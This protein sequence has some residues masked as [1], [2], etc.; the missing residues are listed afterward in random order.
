MITIEPPF[1]QLRGT[2]VFRDHERPAQ[3]YY[4]PTRTVL[5]KGAG[6]L[7]CT[8]YKY[9]RDLTDNPAMTPTK[10]KGAGLA[11]F[12]T[13]LSAPNLT[14]LQADLAS[15]TGLTD[16]TL[17]PVLFRSSVS[18][19][20][21]AHAKGDGLL[22]D[23]VQAHSAPLTMPHHAAFALALSAEGATLF[24]AAARGGQL[25]VGVVYEMRFLAL[26]PALHAKVWMDYERIYDHFSVSTGF[27]YYVSIKFDVDVAFL[28]EHDLVKIEITSFTDAV[29]AQRQRDAIMKLVAMRIQQDFFRSGMPKAPQ[30]GVAGPLG[31]MLNGLVANS[32]EGITSASA[33]FVL[34]ARVEVIRERKDFELR[35]DGRAAVEMTH[36]ASGFLSSMVDDRTDIAVKEIDLDDPFFAALDVSVTAAIDF[37][38]M[39]DLQQ[40]AVHLTYQQNRKSFTFRRGAPDSGRFQAALPRNGDDEYTWE[41]EFFFDTAQGTGDP[42]LA[43]GPFKSRDRALVVQ[44]LSL[45]HYQRL[46]VIRG[47]LDPALVPRLHVTLQLKDTSVMPAAVTARTTMRVTEGQPEA[48][49]RVHLPGPPRVLTAFARTDWEDSRGVV[50]DGQEERVTSDRVV[51]LGPY[52]E[53]LDVRVQPAIDWVRATSLYVEL[54]YRDSDE[55]TLRQVLFTK[56]S[57]QSATVQFPLRDRL[58]RTYEWRQTRLAQDGTS[59]VT[60]WLAS[61][62]TLLVVGG[63]VAAATEVRV[64]WVG[65]AGGALG[66]RVD[67]YADGAAGRLPPASAFLRAGQQEAAIKL[68][69]GAVT[70]VSYHFEVR[71]FDAGG[72]TLVRSGDGRSNLLVVQATA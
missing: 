34:K 13:E 20:I 62:R 63:E 16:I 70:P 59:D 61:D 6:G 66:L 35:Y 3:F 11:L 51:A 41:A 24:E 67:L 31:Q 47:P 60:D 21:V 36:V 71:R 46:G 56:E 33:F 48:L 58:Q 64:I 57:P 40:A 43:V 28:V 30:P 25:P 19:A 18:S 23:L 27:T 9:R 32:S 52:R 4:L 45:F 7:A 1:Y 29:D 15:V 42:R 17:A 14:L 12:E 26:S 72:E 44:P 5:A 49:W 39:A 38:Q 10:A 69:P 53:V 54:R 65:T 50:H 22:E 37:D 2:M 8:L 68:P 55:I